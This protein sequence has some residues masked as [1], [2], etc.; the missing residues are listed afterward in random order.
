MGEALKAVGLAGADFG[1][2]AIVAKQKNAASAALRRENGQAAAAPP[3]GVMNSR[4]FMPI[5]MTRTRHL[6][7]SNEYFDGAKTGIKNLPQCTANVAHE[8][9]VTELGCPRH[10]RSTP[11]SD[12]TADIAACLKR[13]DSVAKVFL[14]G[15]TQILRPVGATIE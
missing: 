7:G 12:R 14:R 13:A 9:I 10:V 2:R 3:R 8:S 1:P 15:G 11:D 6:T 4:R 5:P